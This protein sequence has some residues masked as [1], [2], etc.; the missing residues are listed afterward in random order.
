MHEALSRLHAPQRATRSSSPNPLLSDSKLHLS[1]TLSSDLKFF[2]HPVF[3]CIIFLS[4][5]LS[6]SVCPLLR[7][8]ADYWPTCRLNLEIGANPIRDTTPRLTGMT[9]LDLSAK[10]K[11]KVGLITHQHD[12]EAIEQCFVIQCVLHGSGKRSLKRSLLF[13]QLS[14]VVNF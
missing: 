8:M 12:S 14:L 13:S 1:R 10:I 11:W 5:H 4:S 2:Y 9:G 3:S 7:S 6:N